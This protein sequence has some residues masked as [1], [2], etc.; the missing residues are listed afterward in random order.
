MRA[1]SK[2]YTCFFHILKQIA[3]FDKRSILQFGCCAKEDVFPQANCALQ[4]KIWFHP[5]ACHTGPEEE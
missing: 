1:S 5:V 2:A 4:T 3:T